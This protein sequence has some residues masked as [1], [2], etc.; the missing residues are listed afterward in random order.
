LV[1]GPF[2]PSITLTDPNKITSPIL[3]STVYSEIGDEVPGVLGKAMTS[4][5][6]LVKVWKAN[7]DNSLCYKYF[8]H[9]FA[10]DTYRRFG[11]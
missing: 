4:R 8:C 10:L 1:L 11:Y 6:R 7:P 3:E 2:I 5:G 9:G